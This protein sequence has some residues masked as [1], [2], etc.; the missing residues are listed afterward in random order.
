VCPTGIDIRNGLQLDCV[1]CTAC[2]DACDEVMDRLGR[3]RGLVRYDSERGLRGERTRWVR[4]RTVAFGAVLTAVVIAIAAGVGRRE[5][6]DA[7]ILR[8]PGA[9][10]SVE[11]GLVRNAFSVHIVNKH[12]EAETYLLEPEPTPG[13]TFIVP[14]KEVRVDGGA[15]TFVPM[16]ITVPVT[17]FHRGL[18][19]AVRIRLAPA[20]EPKDLRATLL[21]PDR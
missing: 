7:N 18:P 14:M 10:F 17:D 16:F 20:G 6:Y 5:G 9:P 1:A 21:G 8:L 15:G 12:G 11:Q 19:I 13:V 4:G 2:I 3:P